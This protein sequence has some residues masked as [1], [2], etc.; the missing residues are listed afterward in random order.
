M[1]RM[2]VFLDV[3]AQGDVAVLRGVDEE[4]A[5]LHLCR[6]LV[7][8]SVFDVYRALV[9]DLQGSEMSPAAADAIQEAT[10]ACLRRRQWL[11]ATS[12]AL[13]AAAAVTQARKWLSL[14]DR[15][16]DGLLTVVRRVFRVLR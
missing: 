15:P 3:A 14:V 16:A 8:G 11:V 13:D 5:L 12:S 4:A 2:T 1:V 9:I 6:S 7:T 10:D